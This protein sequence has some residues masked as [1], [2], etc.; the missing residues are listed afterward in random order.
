[1]SSRR[2]RDDERARISELERQ[3]EEA[4][5][6]IAAA[7]KLTAKVQELQAELK[8]QKKL[9]KD[10]AMQKDDFETPDFTRQ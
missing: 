8:D 9:E 7:P 3:R 10:W 1:M 2:K 6:S 4:E 5:Q